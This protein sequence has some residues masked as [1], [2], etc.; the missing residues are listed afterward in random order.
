M[1]DLLCEALEA[2]ALGM[3][4]GSGVQLRRIR[5][6][7][8]ARASRANGRAVRGIYASHVRNRDAAILH[9]IEDFLAVVRAGNVAG[10]ISHLNVRDNTGAPER[11]WER[12]VESM[13]QA[14]ARGVRRPQPMRPRSGRGSES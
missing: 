9:S 2:G 6:A 4:S 1:D 12:A 8:R 7:G 14:R 10:Q 13:M 3:S 11:G 5:L